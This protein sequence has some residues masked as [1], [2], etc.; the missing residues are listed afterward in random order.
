MER[1]VPYIMQANGYFFRQG[2]HADR[3]AEAFRTYENRAIYFTPTLKQALK[4][5]LEAL[6]TSLAYRVPR[7]FRF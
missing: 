4:T 3:L 6:K 7:L 5:F 2:I 1:L